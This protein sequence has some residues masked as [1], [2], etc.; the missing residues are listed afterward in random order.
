MRSAGAK[1]LSL[2]IFKGIRPFARQVAAVAENSGK[3]WINEYPTRN[4]SKESTTLTI[5]SANLWHDWPRY[6]RLEQRLETFARLV[7]AERVDILLLQEVSR[8]PTLRGR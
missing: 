8:T 6:W 2:P 7:E 5:M 1:I 3:L 4:N